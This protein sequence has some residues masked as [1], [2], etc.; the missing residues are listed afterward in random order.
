MI[1]H[2]A[3]DHAGSGGPWNHVNYYPADG[4]YIHGG[5]T[6]RVYQVQAGKALYV[7]SWSR[8]GGPKPTTAVDEQAVNFAGFG[9]PFNHLT[10]TGVL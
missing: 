1:D 3:I 6:G 8:V 7:P 4:T 5:Q 9:L 2:A 10:G